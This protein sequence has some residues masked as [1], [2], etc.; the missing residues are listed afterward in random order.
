[1]NATFSHRTFLLGFAGAV[2]LSAAG[3]AGARAQSSVQQGVPASVIVTVTGR[4]REEPP[5]MQ[6]DDFLV[7]QGKDRRPVLSAVPQ[8]GADNKIDFYVVVDDTSENQLALRYPEIS[9]FLRELP[10][11]SQFAVLYA[12]NGTVIVG[13]ELTADR[14]AAIKKLRLPI[15][16][17]GA[18]GGIYLSVVDVAKRIQLSPGRRAAILLLSNGI[19]TFR[20]VRAS[21][22]GLNPDLDAAVSAAQRKGIIV[23]SI[24]VA[25]SSHFYRSL[26]LV[27]N[28]Q[29]CLARLGDET[30]GEAYFSGT[31]TPINMQ[32]F[33]DELARHLGHQYVVTFAAQ[34]VKKTG[35]YP[36]KVRTEVSG[37]EVDAPSNALIPAR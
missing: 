32:P 20:G 24:Y 9:S 16:R 7:Y 18:T 1:M 17:I 31:I 8:T 2:V 14:E 23:Y 27:N 22:P 13:Q 26:F 30:G 11:P 21:T 10:G 35:L 37:A 25:P 3:A 15:G 5:P 36:I 33:L 34:P 12:R 6:K 4:E 19:D 28:G 29:A